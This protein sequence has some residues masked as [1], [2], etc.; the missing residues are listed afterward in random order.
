MVL[1]PSVPSSLTVNC[2]KSLLIVMAANA[3]VEPSNAEPAVRIPARVFIFMVSS[4]FKS[5]SNRG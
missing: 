2:T 4:S 1:L 5:W 3:A